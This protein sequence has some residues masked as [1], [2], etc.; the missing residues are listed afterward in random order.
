MA[1]QEQNPHLLEEKQRKGMT[2]TIKTLLQTVNN[3]L[4]RYDKIRDPIAR[5]MILLDKLCV[6]MDVM[7]SAAEVMPEE[8]GFDKALC[9]DIAETAQKIKVAINQLFD[10]IQHPTYTKEHPIGL[11]MMNNGQSKLENFD[12]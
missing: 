1:N 12:P 7:V 3:S 5:N 10:W 4:E 9:K 11:E 2:P 8:A 6:G